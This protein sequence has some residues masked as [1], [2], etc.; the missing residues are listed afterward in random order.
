MRRNKTVSNLMR[1]QVN[2]FLF[3]CVLMLS[4][5]NLNAQFTLKDTT[6]VANVDGT[7]Q[8]FILMIPTNYDVT[9]PHD[10]LIALHGHGS[11]RNQFATDTRDECKSARDFAFKHQMIYISPDYRATTSWMG[12][13]AEADVVQIIDIIKTK[14]GTQK[15]FITG[16]SMG[17][18]S[19]MTFASIHPDLISGVTAMNGHANH[20]EF[21]GFQDFIASSY[22]GTKV[23]IP[24]EF[25]KRSAE[26][27]PEVLNM[28]IALTVSGLDNTV[29]AASFIRLENI[30]KQLNRKVQLII[31]PDLGHLTVYADA[32]ASFDYMYNAAYNINQNPV[33][34]IN[35]TRLAGTL[36]TATSEHNATYSASKMIDGNLATWW[37]T[38]DNAVLPQVINITLPTNAKATNLRLTQASW[39]PNMYKAKQFTVESSIDGITYETIC[40]GTLAETNNSVWLDTI[41]YKELKKIRITIKTS[42]SNIQTCGLAEV[43]LFGYPIGDWTTSPSGIGTDGPVDLGLKFSVVK[44]GKIEGIRF[45][46]VAGETGSHTA[47]LWL[48]DGTQL[49]SVVVPENAVTGW[50]TANFTQP[51]DVDPTKDYIASYTANKSYGAKSA[52]FTTEKIMGEVIGKQGLYT[53]GTNYGMPSASYNNS[54]FGIDVNFTAD[55][56]TIVGSIRANHLVVYPN[57]TT[58]DFIVKTDDVKTL[59][60]IFDLTGKVL[61]VSKT[62][63]IE[64]HI[65]ATLKK[66]IYLLIATTESGVKE[67]VRIIKN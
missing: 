33:K 28:P 16:G 23:N 8:K 67:Q 3:L 26:Y 44:N 41:D 40:T 46:Q 55:L 27:W 24:A 11:D 34:G 18:T 50:V 4:I 51:I 30:L 13:K 52:F 56:N 36:V 39:Q 32:M 7:N 65:G 45:Y 49:T 58:N 5:G 43:E 38:P 35:L 20:L 22:G 1:F 2:G 29:P 10:M 64:K 6:F 17:G 42:F 48:V 54:S 59:L 9:K 21:T 31:R 14:Y 62:M 53:F 61:E 66:G 47:K 57:P 63:Q 15:V 60:Q 25:K 37:F 12:P 19:A